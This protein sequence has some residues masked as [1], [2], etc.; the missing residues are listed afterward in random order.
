VKVVV[1]GGS[2]AGPNAGAGCSGYLIVDGDTALVIDLGPGT[3]QE[4]RRHIDFRDLS[5][6]LLSHYHLDHI[7]DIGALRY[8][9]KYNPE[10]MREKLDLL[11]P[12][13]TATKFATWGGVFGDAS[14]PE[15]LE[16]TFTISEYDPGGSTRVGPFTVTM[17]RTVHPVPAYAMR[18]T[19]SQGVALGYTAD[20][21]PSADLAALFDG[22]ALLIAEATEPADSTDAPKKRG[23]LTAS[24]AARLASRANAGGLI[25]THR[26]QEL[27]LEAAALEAKSA[28][29]GPVL[30]ARP[31]LTVYI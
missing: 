3:L 18:V 12:P 5:A 31:G 4:L 14:E 28:F 6:I 15:F 19:D 10:P 26:W 27:G 30:I 1:L 25:L 21:G 23:H 9:G 20:T 7:L 24:E 11:V 22:V 2:A 17:A 13:G 8:L 29:S 16:A